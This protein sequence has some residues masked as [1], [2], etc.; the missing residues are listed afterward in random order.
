LT[1]QSVVAVALAG[2]AAGTAS[3]TIGHL[4]IG[5][6]S[7]HE[8]RAGRRL[9]ERGSAAAHLIEHAAQATAPP[10]T[11]AVDRARAAAAPRAATTVDLLDAAVAAGG[12]QIADLLVRAGYHR[13]L[14][15]WLAGDPAEQWF[16]EAETYG[17]Q[18]DGE[19]D[20]D[21]AASRIVAQVRAV[22]GGAVAV[23]IAAA[24]APDA[25][26]DSPD[27]QTLAGIASRLR[28]PV[29][30]WDSGLEAVVRAAETLREGPLVTVRDLLRAAL[31]A[32]GDG[33][34]LVHE[35]ASRNP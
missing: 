23:V 2:R 20:L 28:T 31:V 7:E 18:P 8:G 27:P 14:D 1:D 13:D 29:A 35:F 15:G 19:G 10:L 5:L 21:R 33:P 25:V 6:A 11:A 9:R 30:S 3:P 16:E 34:R 22:Q 32:G 26:L 4:L 17:F 12:D 24:A